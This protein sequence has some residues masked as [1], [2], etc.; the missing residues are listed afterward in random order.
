MKDTIINSLDF[1]SISIITES[2]FEDPLRE[3]TWAGVKTSIF[4]SF[5]RSW[6]FDTDSS[7]PLNSFLLWIRITFLAISDR[8]KVQSNAE[9]PPPAIKTTLSLYFSGSLIK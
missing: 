5:F 9:S 8:N 2:S 3:I 1:P 4:P 6:T 7:A